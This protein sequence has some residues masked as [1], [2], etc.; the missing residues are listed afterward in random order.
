M[1]RVLELTKALIAIPSVTPHDENC[2]DI[3]IDALE[4]MNFRITRLKQHNVSNFWAQRGDTKPLIVFAGHTDVVPSGPHDQWTTP[5]FTATE[6]KGF[7]YGRGAADM[8]GSLAAMLVACERFLKNHPT[9]PCSLGFL[10]TS[11][12]EGDEFLD[13][14]PHV[15]SYLKSQDV[16]IDYCLLG[17]P[18]SQQHV[19]DTLR[20]GRR[21]SLTGY[22][23]V[24][25]KQGHVAYP[26]L[27]ENPIH[28]AMHA[29]STLARKT[30]DNGNDF[31]PATSLQI[32]NIHAGTGTGNVIPGHLDVQFN[33]RYAPVTDH[34]TLQRSVE[35]ALGDINYSLDWTLNGEPFLTQKGPLTQACQTAIKTVT[36]IETR[37]CTGGGTSDGRFIAPTGAQIVELGPCNT[38]IHQINECISVQDVEQLAD[39]YYHTLIE[40]TKDKNIQT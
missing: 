37:F 21:G 28:H 17:E 35:E 27:A 3:L 29:L 31:F 16:H 6:K 24:H 1:S 34:Q 26:H 12:E 15:L 25:G 32:T 23:T 11:G 14:T 38:T 10:I 36:G 30:W 4:A 22:L 40:L 9:P 2:Q 20:I 39:I 13:G 8:K 7:L 5:P 19:G 18:S 33:F